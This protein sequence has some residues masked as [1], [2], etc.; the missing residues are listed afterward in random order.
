MV[1]NQITILTLLLLKMERISNVRSNERSDVFL[2]TQQT[3][4]PRDALSV[5][6]CLVQTPV[7]K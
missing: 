5:R 3:T 6:I 2:V 4:G 7:L 1:E